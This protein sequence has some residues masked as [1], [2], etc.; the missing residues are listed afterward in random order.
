MAFKVVQMKFLAMY[1]TNKILS[2]DIFT[3]GHLQNIFMEHN[4]N[5]LMIFGLNKI[6]HFYPCS[7]YLDIAT[8]IPE[9]FMIGFV[10][11]GHIYIYIY[12]FSK[13]FYPKRLT[14]EEYNKRC[15]I[16]SQTDRGSAYNTTF[17][18]LFRAKTSK[19][20]RG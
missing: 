2:L 20:R 7:V 9:R 13:C 17:Q 14:I 10:V 1:I 11:Q 16:K 18:A 4:L 3:V 12:S 5:I 15:I 6:D 19:T 8:N